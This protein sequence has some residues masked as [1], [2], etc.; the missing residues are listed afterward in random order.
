MS[1]PSDGPLFE[2]GNAPRVYGVI[3]G[4][5]PFFEVEM[6]AYLDQRVRA[7]WLIPML[8][9]LIPLNIAI[10]VKAFLDLCVSKIKGSNNHEWMKT[11]HNGNGNCY[12]T[13]QCDKIFE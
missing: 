10:C 6:G 12:I 4:L 1:A 11:Y 5:A 2:H 13:N 7:F 9:L 8:V 3:G